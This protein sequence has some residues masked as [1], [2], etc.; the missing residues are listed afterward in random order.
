MIPV[1]LCFENKKTLS[2]ILVK[3][4]KKLTAIGLKSTNTNTNTI[5]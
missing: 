5:I 1:R 4:R 2:L 3:Q